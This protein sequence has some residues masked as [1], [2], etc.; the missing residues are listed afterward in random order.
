MEG[1]FD[2]NK[3]FEALQ[4]LRAAQDKFESAIRAA[5]ANLF[6]PRTP[7]PGC[8]RCG[9]PLKRGFCTDMTCAFSRHVQTCASGWYGLPDM[10]ALCT[11]VKARHD[12]GAE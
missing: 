9:S 1:Y 10:A 12:A 2:V 11:C 5:P 3:V 8:D 4:E 7:D 6:E